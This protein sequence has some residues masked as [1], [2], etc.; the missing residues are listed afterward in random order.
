MSKRHGLDDRYGDVRATTKLSAAFDAAVQQVA[1][2]MIRTATL[3]VGRDEADD[4]FSEWWIRRLEGICLRYDGRVSFRTYAFDS[5]RR[6][7][8]EYLRRRRHYFALVTDDVV[9][10]RQDALDKI[11][12]SD[13]RV[14][15]GRALRQLSK[16]TRTT[17]VMVKLKG[18]SRKDVARRQG[19]SVTTINTRWCRGRKVLRE[20]L[21]DL[22]EY[23]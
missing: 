21:K 5:F 20:L 7:C 15:L 1:P 19:C 4:V 8:K 13:L 9:D 18:M 17:V 12:Q 23:L 16:P 3:Y 22:S 2:A 6:F 10:E 11:W 14:R